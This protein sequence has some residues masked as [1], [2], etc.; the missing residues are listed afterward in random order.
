VWVR[1]PPPAHLFYP[2]KSEQHTINVCFR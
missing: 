2:G 1:S